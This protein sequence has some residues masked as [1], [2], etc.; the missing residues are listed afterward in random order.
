MTFWSRACAL[1]TLFPFLLIVACARAAEPLPQ[2]T[3]PVQHIAPPAPEISTFVVPIR[4]SLASLAPDIEARVPKT[5]AGKERE[6][7]I[8][9]RY[10]VVRD[11]IRLEMIGSGLHAATTVKYAIEACRGRFP[12]I[13]C[14]FDEARRT[15]DIRLQTKLDWDPSWRLRSSTRLL[16]VHYAKPCEVTWL[17]LDI[18]RR[19]VAPVVEQQLGHVAQIIDRSTPALT[20]LRPR[21][22]QIWTS[23]QAPVEL[24]PRTWLV[25][26]PSTVALTPISGS[27]SIVTSTLVLRAQ[28][29]VIV[30]EKP[31]TARKPLP[32]LSTAAAGTQPAVRVPADVHLPYEEAARF[33]P[34]THTIDGK[35]LTIRSVK[36][37][38]AG[39][40]RLLIEADIDY[41][42]GMFR[43]YSGAIFLEGTPRFEQA[44]SRIVIPDLD[45]SLDPK[46]RGFF[47]RIA[48][49]AAHESIRQR[50]RESARFE[51]RARMQTLRDEVTRA[52]NRPLA[53]G[54]LL[55]GRADA[56]EATMAMPAET[57]ILVR[58]VVTGTAEI[59]LQ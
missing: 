36:L 49:R 22:E 6:R 52:L 32:A 19:F 8:D 55:R 10:D 5:F 18:T 16:P 28:T 45:Y 34:K 58:I 12:C 29:R 3:Q 42:G 25:L 38:P 20:N 33:I 23:L 59:E 11:P 26:E 51:L 50:L 13:S 21:A 1:R 39:N 17:D 40:G 47:T 56:V 2:Q 54:V 24:A 14:G 9:V 41:R 48:E 43:N 35:P 7:G 4:T 30:G 31:A 37:S 46:R 27:G 57:S 53:P 15:A 44:T